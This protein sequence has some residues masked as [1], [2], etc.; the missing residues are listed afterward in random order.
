MRKTEITKALGVLAAE[1]EKLRANGEKEEVG[2]GSTP[3]T[4]AVA[5]NHV[6]T[7]TLKRELASIVRREN[8][9]ERPRC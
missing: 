5:A 8:H 2:N 1:A 6:S 3:F 4:K 7:I 9:M